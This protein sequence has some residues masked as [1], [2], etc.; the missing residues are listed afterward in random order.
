MT[1]KGLVLGFL[2]VVFICGFSYFNDQVLRLTFLVGNNM[3]FVFYGVL[4]LFLAVGN[5]LLKRFIP[6]L[7]LKRQEMVLALVI[8]L[9]ACCIPGS[10][11]MRIFNNFMVL[12]HQ[13]NETEAGWKEQ[14]VMDLV[15]KKMLADPSDRDKVVTGYIQGLST[16]SGFIKFKDVPFYA[17]KDA[18]LLWF[19][20]LLS[21]WIALLGL[22]FVVHKQWSKNEHLPYP[23]ATFTTSLL[24]GE[25]NPT[26]G[27][28]FK[29]SL[30]WI[31]TLGVFLIYLNNYLY[32]WFPKVL[33]RIPLRLEFIGM[34]TKIKVLWDGGGWFLG[35]L[36][37]YFAGIGIAYFLASEVSFS[38][39]ISP[40]LNVLLCGILAGYGISIKSVIPGQM[41]SVQDFMNFGA[42]LATFLVLLYT[43]RKYYSTN[44]A[45]A[46][47]IPV[48]EKEDPQAVTGWRIFILAFVTLVILMI[49]AGLDFILAFLFAAIQIMTFLVLGRLFA[50]TGLFYI[51]TAVATHVVITGI[52]GAKSL[53]PQAVFMLFA[54]SMVL[55]HDTREA[56]MPFVVNSLQLADLNGLSSKNTFLPMVV[57]LFLGLSIAFPVQTWLQYSKGYSRQD[58]WAADTVKGPFQQAVLIKQRLINQGT[59]EKS[60]Q[61]KGIKRIPFLSPNPKAMIGIFVGVCLVLLFSFLKL[62]IPKWPLHPLIFL[63]WTIWPTIV[64]FFSFFLG[65]L[66]KAIVMKYGGIRV[67]QKLKPL[68]LG[69]IAGE[70]TA[71]LCVSIF[72]WIY[73]AVTGKPPKSFFIFWN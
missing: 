3:P 73:Y 64:M 2:G 50:E 62:R 31:G 57:A 72:G 17:F 16:Q 8:S 49:L 36:N 69:L 21:L 43:G 30:F 63:T 24:E 41:G 5:P 4:I 34:F 70:L 68:M 52:M 10:G 61:I 65:W 11:L 46:L 1:L 58:T 40:F 29:N 32:E 33:S 15:P 9:A 48:K 13:Y 45:K 44:L 19:P 25:E 67:Y 59:L 22:S 23:L 55:A 37:I 60:M 71:A 26:S 20:L 42:Y 28:I 38:L 12:P 51:S 6:K 56:L 7:A 35:W 54:M 39:A 18:I 27:S 47:L 14:K 53:G 66:I